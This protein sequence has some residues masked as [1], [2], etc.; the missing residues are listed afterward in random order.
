MAPKLVVVGQG[1]V[2]LPI[3]MRAVEVG[4]DVVGLEIDKI[5][6]DSL[7]RVMSYVEDVSTPGP[8]GGA[9]TGR[10]RPTADIEALRGFDYV[11]ITVPTPL[12][13]TVPDLTF[14]EESARQIAPSITAASTVILESTTYPGTTEELLVPMLEQG[15]RTGCRA[16]LPCRLLARTHRPGQH[17]LHLRQHP[18]GGVGHRRALSL[19]GHC[20]LRLTG[21]PGRSG[22]L[23][24]REAELTKLLENTFRHVNIALVNEL[25]VFAH[26]LGINV[27]EAIEAASSK[28]FGFMKFT[29][30]PGVGGHCLPDRP[31]LPVLAGAADPRAYL[32]LRRPRQRRQRSHA[33]LRGAAGECGPQPS[34]SLDQRLR[35]PA[36][37]VGVQEE[38]R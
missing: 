4:Y 17:D 25:A 31:V 37:R 26:D 14:I 10:Y 7:S 2:G 11:V 38:H 19:Q 34:P 36:D 23:S 20:L 21:R 18:E 22:Q 1:Y 30:G 3:A 24:P 33:R 16:R 35:D 8:A 27:W 15:S 29:P 13:E 9:A 28:P 32:S 5:R 12:K 6:V